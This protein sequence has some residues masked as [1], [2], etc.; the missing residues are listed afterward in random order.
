MEVL[1]G[2]AKADASDTR[3]LSASRKRA[4]LVAWAAPQRAAKT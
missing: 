4:G 3:A 2:L 1:L